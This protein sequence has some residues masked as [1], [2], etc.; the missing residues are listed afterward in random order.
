[1][2]ERVRSVHYTSGRCTISNQSC[3]V[4]GGIWRERHLLMTTSEPKNRCVLPLESSL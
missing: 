2:C 3:L 4:D 1:M